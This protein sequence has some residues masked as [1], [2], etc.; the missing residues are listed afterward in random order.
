MDPA[1]WISLQ[2]VLALLLGSMEGV[3][4]QVQA[5]EFPR[6]VRCRGVNLSQTIPLIS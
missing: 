1:R 3:V 5:A 2:C 4:M 6:F